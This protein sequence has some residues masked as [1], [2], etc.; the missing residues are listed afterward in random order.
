MASIDLSGG[1][2]QQGGYGGGGGAP[3]YQQAGAA[4]GAGGAFGASVASAAMQNPEV[5]RQVQAAAYDQASTGLAAARDGAKTAVIE[6]GKYIQEGPA[7]ISV[8]CFL[9][10]LATT[11]IGILGILTVTDG[12]TN[13]FHYVLNIYLTVFGI[14]AVML[15]ADLAA[16]QRLPILGKLGPL[17]EK[18]QM[19]IFRKANFL[20]ELFGRGLFYIFVGTLA[21]TQCFVCLL[22][23]AGLWNLLMGVVCVL[24]SFGI[25]PV[26]N[27]QLQQQGR[28]GE[29]GMPLNAV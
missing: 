1:G 20:T 9:G 27:V 16:L 11:V 26:E 10:G 7:G 23:L 12:L 4:Q 13:P 2:G 5:Q 29:Q 14:I 28:Q 8:L 3:Q 21:I 18:Y 6:L 19:D 25:N 15:E 17:I 22:F 24:M